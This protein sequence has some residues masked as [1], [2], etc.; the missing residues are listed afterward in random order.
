MCAPLLAKGRA[1]G[2]LNVNRYQAAPGVFRDEDLRVLVILAGQ[3]ALCIENARLHEQ[4]IQQARLAAIGQTVAGISHCVKNMLTGL[5]GGM[6][7]LEI[8]QT[9]KDWGTVS[10]ATGFI[11]GN[12]ERI[13]ML[14]MDMLDYSREKTPYRKITD[15]QKLADEV[16]AVVH[17]K[18]E[19]LKIRLESEIDPAC[20]AHPVDT[21]QIFRCLLNL[22]ENAMDALEDGGL[23]RV[24]AA[25]VAEAEARAIFGKDAP[26]ADMGRIVR[27]SVSDNGMGIPSENIPLLFQ[28]FFSI[29]KS[30]GTG[31][32]LAV[33]WKIV[34]EHGGKAL[35]E[36]QPGAGS[37]IHLIL[38]EKNPGEADSGPTEGQAVGAL[39]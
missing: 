34:T 39:G 27:L 25:P 31:L 30:K 9:S 12:I 26:L 28:P 29:K 24:Q 4:I 20:A 8:A 22:V 10:K 36:S 35:V 11:K 18:A 16:F 3:A 5:R 1:I 17:Y 7:I 13:S 2:A 23:V 15:L 37:S 38:P 33:T 21:D 6:G 14:V 19:M 32:G